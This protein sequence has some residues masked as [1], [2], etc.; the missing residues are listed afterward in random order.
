MPAQSFSENIDRLKE[1]VSE[2]VDKIRY[3]IGEDLSR[4]SRRLLSSPQNNIPPSI[5]LPILENSYLTR[6]AEGDDNWR[7]A[8]F[9]KPEVKKL[10]DHTQISPDRIWNAQ[11]NHALEKLKYLSLD[12]SEITKATKFVKGGLVSQGEFEDAIKAVY[13]EAL[14]SPNNQ[15]KDTEIAQKHINISSVPPDEILA[16]RKKAAELA[17]TWIRN[18]RDTTEAGCV[19]A[20][21]YAAPGLSICVSLQEAFNKAYLA[22]KLE[23]A[24]P[25]K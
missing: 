24:A 10:F 16:A 4:D 7:L 20:R 13:L 8:V 22:N 9:D 25:S 11:R 17:L 21:K 6:I 5:S 23:Q 14:W 2:R 18:G 19:R 12:E 15:A 1:Q 3:A